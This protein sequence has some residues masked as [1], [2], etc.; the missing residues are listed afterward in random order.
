MPSICIG[1]L[2]SIDI[3]TDMHP[4]ETAWKLTD[5]NDRIVLLGGP[6]LSKAIAYVNESCLSDR[7][8]TFSIADSYS[9]GVCCNFG[10]GY[11]NIKADGK[12]IKEGGVFEGRE[13]KTFTAVMLSSSPSLAPSLLPSEHPS[14][15]PSPSHQPTL[16]PSISN[17]PSKYPSLVPSNSNRPTLLPSIST[18]PSSLASSCS[19][20]HILI[21]IK[22][23]GSPSETTWNI[24]DANDNER[25]SAHKFM[26]NLHI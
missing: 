15:V 22:T 5:S 11:Y 25:R 17:A 12:L 8:H 7:T 16:T 9:D 21:A 13:E 4:L 19:V 20:S 1:Q 23:D 14:L 26:Q 18:L 10:N 24:C 6:Y 3:K 2:V